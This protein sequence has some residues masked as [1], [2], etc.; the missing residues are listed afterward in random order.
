[1][2]VSRGTVSLIA[3]EFDTVYLRVCPTTR[4]HCF[5][6]DDV[7]GCAYRCAK[8]TQDMFS[9]RKTRKDTT[10]SVPIV[11]P[12]CP[13]SC[14][15]VIQWYFIH[16]ILPLMGETMFI[17]TQVLGS[18]SSLRGSSLHQWLPPWCIMELNDTSRLIWTQLFI[19]KY[20]NLSTAS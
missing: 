16:N 5:C 10:W 14:I 6:S 2:A 18:K 3:S 13:V 7:T 17:E 12:G 19:I 1:M 20:L 9:G 11:F 8:C 4:W 15:T